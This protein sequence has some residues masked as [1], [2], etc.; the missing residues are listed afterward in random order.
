MPSITVPALEATGICL[1][2]YQQC[3]ASDS[4]LNDVSNTG[5]ELTAHSRARVH[6]PPFSQRSVEPSRSAAKTAAAHSQFGLPSDDSKTQRHLG[7]SARPLPSSRRC[8]LQC[9]LCQ[10]C[11]KAFPVAIS[12]RMEAGSCMMRAQLLWRRH[13]GHAFGCPA[14]TS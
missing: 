9:A 14:W 12:A 11:T 8:H 10:R 2:T 4:F 13:A 3:I 7:S 1:N 5:G 6:L